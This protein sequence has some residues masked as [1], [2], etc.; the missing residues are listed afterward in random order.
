MFKVEFQV[1]VFVNTFIQNLRHIKKSVWFPIMG[2]HSD[3][4]KVT[5]QSHFY[6]TVAYLRR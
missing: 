1:E 5:I 4:R 6:N 2:K 3:F